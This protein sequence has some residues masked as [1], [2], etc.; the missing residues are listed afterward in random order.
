[1]RED[2]ADYRLSVSA[3]RARAATIDDLNY[4]AALANVERSSQL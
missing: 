4:D 3:E 1:M 2:L